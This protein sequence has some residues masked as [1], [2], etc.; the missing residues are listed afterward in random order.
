MIGFL[1]VAETHKFYAKSLQNQ[2]LKE[3]VHEAEL[4]IKTWTESSNK[5]GMLDFIMYLIYRALKMGYECVYYYFM[6]FIVVFL[7]FLTQG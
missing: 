4:E 3:K 5:F 6:P 2:P 1:V 7:T